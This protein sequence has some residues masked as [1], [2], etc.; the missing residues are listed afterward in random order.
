MDLAQCPYSYSRPAIIGIF[1]IQQVCYQCIF[2]SAGILFFDDTDIILYIMVDP[3]P[4]GANGTEE[5]DSKSGRDR[6]NNS[7]HGAGNSHFWLEL[8]M[9]LRSFHAFESIYSGK[10]YMMDEEFFEFINFLDVGHNEAEKCHGPGMKH[11]TPNLY[12]TGD[13]QRII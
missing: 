8:R 10:Q 9:F 2:R 11:S 13:F 3:K 1:I 6:P 5:K 12:K 4:Q 7:F